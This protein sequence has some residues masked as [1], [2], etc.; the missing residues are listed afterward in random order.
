[1]SFTFAIASDLHIT[2][3]ETVWEHP[4]RFHLVEFSIAAFE[5]VLADL[6]NLPLDCLL[7]PG[8]LTQHGESANHRWLAQ[9]LRQ[10][11]YP[12]YV[13]P[14]NHDVLCPAQWTEFATVYEPFGLSY[15]DPARL[16]YAVDLTPEVRLIALN[17]NQYDAGGGI[18]GAVDESQLMWLEQTL[19]E[20][21]SALTMVMIHHCVLEHFPGHQ[22]GFGYRY[23]LHNGDRLCQ[24]LQQ[25]GVQLIFS[26]HLHVQDVAQC[27]RTGVYDIGTGSLVS[28]PHPYRLCQYN[29]RQLSIATRHIT[30]VPEC[31]NLKEFAREWMGDRSMPFVLRMLSQRLPGVD[32]SP[33]HQQLRYFWAAIAAGDAD[34]QFPE[35]PDQVRIYLE[36]FGDRP[37]ADNHLTLTL[38]N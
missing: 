35:L 14:G 33:W 38:W 22:G 8:D 34:F 12:T 27:D 1:M 24:L 11:P 16:Y 9:R 20:H 10:L 17:S 4:Q 31:P 3:P 21:S 30:S 13:I 5:A 25:Y 7:L 18:Y 32:F 15:S 19:R 36:S 2:L 37:P 26:G 6:A 28:Y 23:L 29:G